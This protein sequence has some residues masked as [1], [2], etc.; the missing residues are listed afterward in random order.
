MIGVRWTR[1]AERLAGMALAAGLF[2]LMLLGSWLA[3]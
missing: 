2:G 3:S 1:R